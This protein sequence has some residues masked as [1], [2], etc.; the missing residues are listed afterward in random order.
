MKTMMRETIKKIMIFLA[1]AGVG[2]AISWQFFK[3]KYKRIADE[4]IASVKEVF[5]RRHNIEV[6]STDEIESDS[7]EENEKEDSE[8]KTEY[9]NL[10]NN[11]NTITDEINNEEK[12]GNDMVNGP[13]VIKPEEFDTI[14]YDVVSLTYYADKVLTDENDNPI[15]DIDYLVGEDSLD[16]FGE[17]EDDSVFVRND[18]LKTDFEIL[19]D[20]ASYY[21]EED[22]E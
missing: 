12:G 20:E 5:E 8:I 4:E 10:A 11:Y 1:G 15:E 18:D 9:K 16:H 14:G 22:S 19:L 6:V 7:V 21:D 2:T 3:N 17:Y 13:Y